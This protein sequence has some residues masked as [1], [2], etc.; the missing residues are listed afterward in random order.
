MGFQNLRQTCVFKFE[1]LRDKGICNKLVNVVF[2]I[3]LA[4][5]AICKTSNRMYIDTKVFPN[6]KCLYSFYDL[7]CYRQL[8]SIN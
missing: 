8:F 6:L 5:Y 3:N 7:S 1:V 4:R 2:I